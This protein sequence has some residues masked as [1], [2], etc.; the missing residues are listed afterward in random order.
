MEDCEVSDIFLLRWKPQSVYLTVSDVWISEG[1]GSE[2]PAK[3]GDAYLILKG[4]VLRERA[5][6][7]PLYLL[8]RQVVFAHRLLHQVLVVSGVGGHLVNR[9][10]ENRQTTIKSSLNKSFCVIIKI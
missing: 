9:P 4:R 7:V 2:D 8:R 3:G 6:Q 5:V 1:V 10:Y